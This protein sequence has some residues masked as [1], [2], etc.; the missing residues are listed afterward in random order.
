MNTLKS[1][2]DITALESEYLTCAQIAGVLHADP[3]AIHQT[4]VQRPELLGFPVIVYGRRV[5]VPKMP[6]VRFM[7]GE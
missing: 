1:L 2:D 4:A 6:F 3:Y 7:R 5:K